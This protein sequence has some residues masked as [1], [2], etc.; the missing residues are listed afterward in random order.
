MEDIVER[1]LP[2]ENDL[3]LWL[4]NHHTDF[5]DTFMSIYTGKVIWIPL[6]IILLFIIVYRSDWR[7]TVLF[8]CCFILLVTLC[9]QLSSSVIKP[10]FE[11][12]RPTHHPDFM[13]KV[14][15]V[16]NYR[17]GRYGF[18]S[19]HATNGFGV[20]VF[21]SLVFKYRWFTIT[22]IGWTLINSYTRIY[23]GVHFVTDILGGMFLGTLL[24]F[25]VYYIYQYARVKLLKP[26]DIESFEH[27]FSRKR[28]NIIIA[29]I[30]VTVLTIIIYSLFATNL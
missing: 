9:D 17:G 16:N 28:A 2:Y 25:L 24:G 15:T 3:F 11:R 8:I 20:A 18:I 30:L 13:D 1:T 23:L 26:T 6:S 12:L 22:V 29:S 19:A 14:I 4:N 21:L 5:W 7:H 27:P 10:F